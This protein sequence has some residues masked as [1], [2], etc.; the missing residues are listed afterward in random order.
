MEPYL[1]QR[2]VD[3]QPFLDV[4]VWLHPFDA[5]LMLQLTDHLIAKMHTTESIKQA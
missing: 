3:A 5:E 1:S 4:L 2:I